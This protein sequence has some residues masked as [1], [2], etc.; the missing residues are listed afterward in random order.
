MPSDVSEV[1]RVL[2]VDDD[3]AMRRFLEIVLRRAGFDVSAAGNGAEAV[4][5]LVPASPDAE[6]PV[7][8]DAVL[9]DAMLPDV[10][11]YDLARRLVDEPA[12][13]RLPICFLSGAIHGRVSADAGIAC[14]SKPSTPG[15]L[16]DALEAIIGDADFEPEARRAAVDRVESL[17]FL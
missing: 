7:H 13:A 11:G 5:A 17:S 9:L 14:V 12:T 2:V 6:P 16:V 10:R 1:R 15:Q 8:A 4:A 3:P